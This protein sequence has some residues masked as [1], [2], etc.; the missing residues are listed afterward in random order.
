MIDIM[1]CETPPDELLSSLIS[2]ADNLS[3]RVELVVLATKVVLS[4][5]PSLGRLKALPVSQFIEMAE[6]PLSALKKKPKSGIAV[7]INMVREGKAQGFVTA[8]NTGALVAFASA[9]TGLKKLDGIARPAL[10][11]RVPTPDREMTMLD[12]GANINWKASHLI[13]YASI[14]L[15]Y[16]KTLGV[17]EPTVGLLNIGSEES[18]GT[19][20]LRKVFAGLK[21]LTSHN[22]ARFLENIEGKRAFQGGIDLLITDGFTG[23]VFLKT[24]E[25][26]ALYLLEML[27]DLNKKKPS[28]EFKSF[29]ELATSRL[30]AV[31][32]SG[33]LLAGVDGI[34]VKCHG[35][36]S[37]EAFIQGVKNALELI[38]KD[39]LKKLSTQLAKDASV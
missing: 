17:E 20:E 7:G 25:G 30:Q 37:K 4:K 26:I 24:S 1:G 15:A 16:L 31:Q 23:N 38:E 14:G 8:G 10:L 35:D 12:V 27:S 5:Y 39:F 32:Y 36:S 29:F 3:S 22:P 19:P 33:A 28:A 9:K 21:Q 34:V 11:I 13:Q 2:F 18:K 6:E